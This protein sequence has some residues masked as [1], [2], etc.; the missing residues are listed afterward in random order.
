MIY[1]NKIFNTDLSQA[2]LKKSSSG[3]VL[4]Q[5]LLKIL[6]NSQENI[7]VRFSFLTKLQAEA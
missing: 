6:R 1:K 7:C 4:H 2:F 3:S 5:V